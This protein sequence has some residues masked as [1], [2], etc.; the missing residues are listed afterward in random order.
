MLLTVLHPRQVAV[1]QAIQ[2]HEVEANQLLQ[3]ASRYYETS[4][5]KEALRVLERV[6][7]IYRGIGDLSEEGK[8]LNNIGVIYSTLGQDR[9]A[10]DV[11]QQAL[12]IARQVNNRFGEA[13]TLNNI[14]E[15]H[16]NLGEYA[17]ALSF[18]EQALVISHEL[19]SS[20]LEGQVL[21]NIG[22][23]YNSLG[24][25]ERALTFSQQALKIRRSTGDQ[26]GEGV[27]SSNI[28]VTYT[29]LGQYPIALK[30]LQRALSISRE[31]RDSRGESVVLNNLGK[32]HS[33]VGQY[34]K[35]L[36][37]YQQDIAIARRIGD[38][39]G[40]GTTL[41]NI[42]STYSDLGEYVKAL[43]FQHQAL[44]VHREVGN[45]AGE[46]TALNNI[47]FI[48][49]FQKQYT[50]ALN[51]HNQALSIRRKLG[52]RAGEA[53]A[54]NNI[55]G[56]YN[57]LGKDTEALQFYQQALVI[58][59]ESGNL[60]Q[61]A[62]TL[63]NIGAS[64]LL[65]GNSKVAESSLLRAASIRDSLRSG[66]SDADKVSAL[67]MSL[68][69]Y[70]FLQDVFVAQSKISEA[71]EASER[72][73][74]RALADLLF[75]RLQTQRQQADGSLATDVR[76]ASLST[77]QIKQTAQAQNAILVQYSLSQKQFD[78]NGHK[79]W[80]DSV[81]YIWVVQSNGQIAF[82]KVNVTPLSK[83]LEEFVSV[84]RDAI[85]VRSRSDRSLVAVP[86]S[87][88]EQQKQALQQLHKILI[89]PIADLLPKDPN[90]RVA[91]MP[92]DSLFL[93]PFAAL[94]DKDGKYLVEKH[95]IVTAPSIQT[96]QL[97]RETKLKQKAQTDEALIVGNPIM[98]KFNETQLSDLPGAKQEAIAISKLFSTQP[99]I[100]AQATKAEVV[101][102]MKTAKYIHLATHGL[103]DSIKGDIPGA[104]ALTP[105]ANNNGFLTA[106]EIFEM[107]LNADLVVLS[108]C[109]T[110]RGDIKGEGVI[111]LSR[112]LI[113][114]GVPSVIVSLWQVPDSPTASLMT[115]FYRNLREKKLDK[116]QSLRQAMLTTMKQ[117]PNPRDWAAFTLIGESE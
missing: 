71:L 63:S 32:L 88:P 75:S 37:F 60:D 54:L 114:A 103:L 113:S 40:E 73:R 79:E 97:T 81:L 36:V 74:A 53:T 47:G 12:V 100:G 84:S 111:G 17:K 102:R 105:D 39:R 85:G 117:H 87:N 61:E 86:A 115:E 82:R 19:R 38:R 77:H 69:T 4:Q 72:G 41:G 27:T 66:L 68:S 93:V 30:Y 28:G 83:S 21:S 90:Q 91:F 13:A 64:S 22:E 48:Y 44:A 42:G 101:K 50:Q 109:D 23:V 9:V 92:Q 56:V 70:R 29:Q 6:L 34:R 15:V 1:A 31:V 20:K 46:A 55:G 96:L 104:I 35:S 94:Q 80:R 107:Q 106:G 108:A 95:T 110:A 76:V 10:S 58:H 62:I 49:N 14:G 98:P 18:Y 2:D 8:T 116:A 89:E 25:Y 3:Q 43:N 67:D 7:Q 51:F 65:L 52:D 11:Y 45:R 57:R 78:A 112:S 59:R 16:R 24:Q 33:Q 5:F 99:L 26:V